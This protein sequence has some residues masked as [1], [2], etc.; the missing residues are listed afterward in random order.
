MDFD[1]HFF[2]HVILP[3]IIFAGG[4]NL[5][6]RRFFYCFIYILLFGLVATILN[7]GLTTGLTYAFNAWGN[8]N[9]L[10][11][12]SKNWFIFMN[13]FFDLIRGSKNKRKGYKS[14]NY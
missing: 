13:F 12:N 10:T 11:R 3:P 9:N 6:T 4:Y 14:I 5:Q 8:N 1:E 2:F 7:F